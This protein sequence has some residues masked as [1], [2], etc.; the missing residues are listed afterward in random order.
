MSCDGSTRAG[1]LG[2]SNATLSLMGLGGFWENTD[3]KSL[4]EAQQELASAQKKWKTKLD[5]IKGKITED[6][7]KVLD[8]QIQ[9]ASRQH[10]VA[11]EI[12]GEK[13]QKNTLVIGMLLVLV[14]F[15]II[16]DL[17]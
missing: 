12:L 5:N 9:K 1:F 16:F 4:K 10:D 17:I 2:A 15:L 7:M 14:F 6:E 3:S 13:I 11:E 8:I